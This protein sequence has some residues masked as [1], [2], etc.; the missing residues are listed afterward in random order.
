MG[1]LKLKRVAVSAARHLYD[2][3]IPHA[4]NN[5]HPHILGH[6]ALAL[7]S[8]LLVTLKIFTLALLSFGPV[9][10]AFSSAITPANIISL[11][12]QSRE[13]YQLRDLS[14]NLVLDKAAQIKADDMLARGY[15]S[16][17]TPDGKTPWD[18]ITG[19]GYGYI[20]A[21]ENLA[22]NFTEA[23]NVEQ[24]W[25]D[26]PGHKANIVNKNFEEIGIGISQGEYQGHSA[27]F[28]VQMFG[29]PAEQKITLTD[30]PTRVQ[31]ESVPVPTPASQPA[32]AASLAETAAGKIKPL[33]AAS[34]QEIVIQNT[35]VITEGDTVRISAQI[36]A[37]AVKA[38]AYFGQKGIMLEPRSDGLWEGRAALAD[39]A[40]GNLSVRIEASDILGN[41]KQ[42]GLADFASSTINNFNVLGATSPVKVS[43]LGKVF[44][45]KIFEQRFYLLFIAGLLASM[46]LAIGIKR[47]I[48]HLSLIT[49]SSF[50]IMLAAL[51]W[52]AG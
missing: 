11:T 51:L 25:M 21:G 26:S 30:T 24:A 47:H 3:F 35:Q 42:L 6:K 34:I 16:H 37:N 50:V 40:R 23:E 19:S 14:E 12:N 38:I 2:H 15:F 7:F 39:F 32:P 46:I 20:M 41:S 44:D 43:W 13:S 8:G 22:V 49:N 9:I 48:Q 52:M 45:P 29:T 31:T 1:Q 33:P 27:I 17:N 4:R 36:S 18:F 5:Y 28:V 10:P